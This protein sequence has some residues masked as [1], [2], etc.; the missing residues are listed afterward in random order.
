MTCRERILSNDYA[1]VITEFVFSREFAATSIVDYCYHN[2]ENDIGI[3]YLERDKIPPISIA[4]GGYS[5][6][7]KCYGLMQLEEGIPTG[8]GV[9]FDPI[10]LMEA[11]ILSLQGEPLN[12]TG[13]GVTIGFIDTGIQYQNE[14]FKNGNGVTRIEAIWDQTIQTGNLPEGFEYGSEYTRDMIQEALSSDNPLSIVPT[15]DIIGHGTAMASVAAGS[16]LDGSRR[17]VGAA[18]ECNIV[19]VKLKEIKQYL[20]EYYMIPDDV[21][22]Y[23][24]T[25]IMQAIQYLQKFAVSFSRTL[26]ICMGIGTAL[27]DHTGSAPL[28][29]YLDMVT[30]KKVRV[31][32]AAGGNEG[33]AAH[34][35]S[36]IIT[37]EQQTRNVEIRVG[38]EEKGFIMDFWGESPNI[39]TVSI[40]SPGGENI[41]RIN[42]RTRATQEFTF[43]FERTRIAVDY[44]L[45]EQASGQQLIRFRFEA[46]TPGIWTITVT[47]EGNILQGEFNMWLPI[48]QFLPARTQ[49][50]EPDPYT[51]MTDPSYVRNAIGVTTYN[52]ENNSLYVDAGRGYARNNRI[53]PDVA[54]PGVNISTILGTRTGSSMAAAITAG[55]AAQLMQWAIVEENDILADSGNIRNYL[56]RGARREASQEYPNR[57]WGYGRL[58]VAGVFDFVAGRAERR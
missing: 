44:L 19:M 20:R 57:D 58:D 52:T 33:N 7:P 26:V 38:E 47:G 3:L 56:I 50:L 12:L 40:R 39:F 21:P 32:V 9:S 29:K 48:T 53:K 1:D 18:P 35:F 54:A 30:A 8:T 22:C 13:R 14:V 23:Q 41:P 4:A 31:V 45:I 5:Y 16:R 25:D 24:E 2:I 27:G 43:I 37:R 46:P 42:P 55:G 28:G 17:F 36:G 11:G 15:T 10:N 49:F 51:T 6:L 34:H